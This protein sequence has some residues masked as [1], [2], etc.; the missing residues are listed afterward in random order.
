M[1]LSPLF[2]GSASCNVLKFGKCG[3]IKHAH[4][5]SNLLKGELL[6]AAVDF[7][8][9]AA[10]VLSSPGRLLALGLSSRRAVRFAAR[11]VLAL[12]VRLQGRLLRHRRQ[13]EGTL[14]LFCAYATYLI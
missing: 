5:D 13:G 12:A 7:A 3:T 10:T 1:Y 8:P 4:L 14:V 9:P 6:V 11:P 2:G